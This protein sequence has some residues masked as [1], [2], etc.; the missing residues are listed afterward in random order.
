MQ[1]HRSCRKGSGN[2]SEL[3]GWP[4]SKAPAGATATQPRGATAYGARALGDECRIVRAAP[5]GAQE[6]TVNGA[7]LRIGGL[8]AGGEIAEGE[9]RAAL[10]AAALAMPSQPGR[11]PW[12]AEELRRKVF[13]ALRDGAERPRQAPK[14]NAGLRIAPRPKRALQVIGAATARQ[15][16]G[17]T[18]D[19]AFRLWPEAVPITDT[20]A[21]RYLL[22]CRRILRPAEGWPD[23]LRFHPRAWRN[24][25]YGPHGPAMLALMTTPEADPRVGV[26]R[27]CGVH[28]TYLRADGSGKADG[29]RPKIMLGGAGVVRLVEDAEVTMGLGLAEGIE[30]ALTI[31]QRGWS[32]VWAAGSAGVI[33]TFP[34]L[35]GIEA[36]TIFA[37][38][39]P[40]GLSAAADCATRWSAAGREGVVR[41]PLIDGDWNDVLRGGAA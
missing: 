13:R 18:H 16:K 28:V 17:W 5:F 40:R 38:R 23:V 19:L 10:V 25:V 41:L 35:G 24:R 14:G 37:D 32:P 30:T 20:L 4:S 29:P 2:T 31:L 22:Q 39:D 3:A 7:A 21:E 27:P 34:V 26:P 33:R 9:A 11:P 8:V 15:D 36:L 1:E 6:A 12:T